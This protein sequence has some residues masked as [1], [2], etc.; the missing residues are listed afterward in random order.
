MKAI[1]RNNN[2]TESQNVTLGYP[3]E[4]ECC[5]ELTIGQ[6][7]TVLGINC[8]STSRINKGTAFLLRDDIGRCSFVPI[9][10][11]EVSNPSPS[12]FWVARID[13]EFDF[14]LWPKEFCI[15]YFLDDL[16]NGIPEVVA[17]FDQVCRELDAENEFQP[18]PPNTPHLSSTKT[19]GQ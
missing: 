11:L 10:L 14:C 19:P 1:L 17:A 15:E 7:Y 9:C 18:L 4:H 3:A 13:N 5:F 2:L 16:T 12:K 6:E 8:L